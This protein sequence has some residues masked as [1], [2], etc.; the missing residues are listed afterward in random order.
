MVFLRFSVCIVKSKTR[1]EWLRG[2]LHGELMQ[3]KWRNSLKEVPV[4]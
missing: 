3:K 2:E 1:D 4:R